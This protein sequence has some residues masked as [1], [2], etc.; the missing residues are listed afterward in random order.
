VGTVEFGYGEKISTKAD[1]Y[2]YGVLLLEMVTRRSP[3][4]GLPVG[5]NSMAEWVRWCLEGDQFPEIIVAE[6]IDPSLSQAMDR[7]ATEAAADSIMEE[8]LAV[9]RLGVVC[10]RSDPK[11]R[12]AMNAVLDMLTNTKKTKHAN[13]NANAN[14]ASL[15]PQR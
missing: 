8:I 9:L 15:P 1:V 10:C 5:F 4:D 3:T 13:V 14:T 6:V 12:P 11:E 2:S 7:E